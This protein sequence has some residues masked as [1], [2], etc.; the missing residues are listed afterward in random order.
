MIME[1]LLTGARNIP[2]TVYYRGYTLQKCWC[3]YPEMR[4]QI[5][6]GWSYRATEKTL[7]LAK[8]KCDALIR[9]FA[10]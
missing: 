6:Y 2:R 1:N 3:G 4:W 8:Q 5:F 9:N 7:N 10:L